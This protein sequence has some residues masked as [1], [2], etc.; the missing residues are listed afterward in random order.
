MEEGPVELRIKGPPAGTVVL[1]GGNCFP[2]AASRQGAKGR[3]TAASLLSKSPV[4][5]T[6]WL[7]PGGKWVNF[8]GV[9]LAGLR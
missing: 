7:S 3:N 6:H 4:G 2:K 9:S 5:P 1:E 8:A